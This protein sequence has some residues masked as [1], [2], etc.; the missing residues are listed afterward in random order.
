MNN[1]KVF[2]LE[3][4][5]R[6]GRYPRA[7]AKAN[8]TNH[9]RTPLKNAGDIC[10]HREDGLTQIEVAQQLDISLS[11]VEKHLANALAMLTHKWK[12]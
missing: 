3:Q 10:L 4:K 6:S 1:G 5:L 9:S 8:S 2:H 11:T 7:A 12:D